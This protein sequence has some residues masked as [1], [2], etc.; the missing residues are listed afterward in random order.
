[1][2][3]DGSL[4][5]VL[6]KESCSRG[7]HKTTR[8]YYHSDTEH[9]TDMALSPSEKLSSNGHDEVNNR[10]ARL[11]EDV[12]CNDPTRTHTCN[13]HETTNSIK[14]SHDLYTDVFLDEREQ[15]ILCSKGQCNCRHRNDI[16]YKHDINHNKATNK[17][18]SDHDCD[19]GIHSDSDRSSIDSVSSNNEKT[20][21]K[22]RRL[23]FS[24]MIS[25]NRLRSRFRL[26]K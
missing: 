13:G 12:S 9:D 15:H 8:C 16:D 24:H 14:S 4:F 1:M 23:H 5:Y 2:Q 26:E 7:K 22:H 17:H 11:V 21:T 19:S 6:V 25:F 20:A 18:S 10:E 3:N